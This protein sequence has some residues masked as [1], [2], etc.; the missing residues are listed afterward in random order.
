MLNRGGDELPSTFDV[1]KA[2]D[3]ELQEIMEN[4]A[5]EHRRPL[6]SNSRV[7]PLRIAHA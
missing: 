4:T 5:K 3:I 1:A 7:S 2:D 6:S